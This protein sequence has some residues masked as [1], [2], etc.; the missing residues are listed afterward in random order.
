MLSPFVLLV[1]FSFS[2]AAILSMP[3]TGWSLRWYRELFGTP[4]FWTALKNSLII[5]TVVGIVSTAVGTMAAMVLARTPPARA[6]IYMGALSLPV[7][8][9]PLV[10][11]L[12]LLTFFIGA[13]LPLGLHTV[14]LGHLVYTQ[15]FVILIAYARMASFDMAILDSARDLGA[16]PWTT[17]LTVVLPI[18]RPTIIGAG[19]V[20][21]ALSLD[22][23]VITLFTIGGG[24]TLPTFMW[25]MLRKGVNPSINVVGIVLVTL[26]VL[27]SG[28]ALRATRYRG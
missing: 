26:I 5:G 14:I 1:V 16:S 4:E 8:L 15:P 20:S 27:A 9:P 24:N 25:G 18:V 7:M 22:D 3:I 19:L 12:S 17:F 11:S 6:N 21:I 10:L 28:L 2:D 13:G 23:F